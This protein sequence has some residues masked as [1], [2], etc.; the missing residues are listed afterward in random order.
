MRQIP[1]MRLV[2]TRRVLRMLPRVWLNRFLEPVFDSGQILTF[3]ASWIGLWLLLTGGVSD[4][5]R[6]NLASQWA[7]AIQAFVLALTAWAFISLVC[8]PFIIIHRD[9]LSGRWYGHRYV[10]INPLLAATL[11]CSATGEPQFHK[12]HIREVE[13][14]S[15][16]YY[17]I[18]LENDPPANLFSATLTS[19]EGAVLVPMDILP[20]QGA[21]KGG[22]RIGEDGTAELLIVMQEQMISQTVRVY[23][24]EFFVGPH[25][26]SQDGLPG[27][28]RPA[29]KRYLE[30]K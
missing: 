1:N 9:R 26:D 20:G 8:A 18:H 2:K 21:R 30:Q 28:S 4:A 16:I 29:F 25:E 10:F 27:E 22:T 5:E 11:R 13:P 19:S 15:F 24:S 14:D 7:V 6:D 23:I 17:K 12:F 3:F